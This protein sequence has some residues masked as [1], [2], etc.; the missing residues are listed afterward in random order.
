MESSLCWQINIGWFTVVEIFMSSEQYVGTYKHY[1]IMN[2]NY[3]KMHVY[4][5]F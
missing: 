1:N 5:F 2:T 3:T 4:T